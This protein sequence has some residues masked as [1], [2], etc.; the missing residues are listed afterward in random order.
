MIDKEI[1]RINTAFSLSHF[2][3]SFLFLTILSG[4]YAYHKYSFEK[5]YAKKQ[6]MQAVYDMEYAFVFD[7]TDGY[8]K[9]NGN[10]YIVV[11]DLKNRIVY[12][13]LP[14]GVELSALNKNGYVELKSYIAF[15]LNI[16]NS[17][18]RIIG[19]Y[20]TG[21]I[22]T[23][24]LKEFVYYVAVSFLISFVLGYFAFIVSRFWTRRIVESY[25]SLEEFNEMFSHEVLTPISSALFYIEDKDTR[26]SLLQA[27]EFLSNF[28]NFQKYKIVPWHKKRVDI[29][30]IISVVKKEVEYLAKEKSI[31]FDI[32]V[33]HKYI[34]SNSEFL[35]FIIKNPVENAVKFAPNKGK[36]SL[37][38]YKDEKF[39]IFEIKNDTD[40]IKLQDRKF[41]S[42]DGFGLGL[43]ITKKMVE[44]LNGSIDISLAIKKVTVTIK[45]PL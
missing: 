4:L 23:K 28:L 43:H 29:E 14:K 33:R 32:D 26:E 3:I 41:Y 42:K 27:K 38:V 24:H 36:V 34:L 6:L 11:S 1:K 7:D 5:G 8:V 12:G 44:L 21:S 31:N 19:F 2:I 10:L 35:Y 37:Y 17:V 18:Y 25:N 39:V 22:Y 9:P 30:S 13:F 40:D 45:L 15:I 16:K 20:D